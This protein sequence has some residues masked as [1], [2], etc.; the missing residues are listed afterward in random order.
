MF[1]GISCTLWEY[2]RECTL[3]KAEAGLQ[4]TLPMACR[5]HAAF[6]K[7]VQVMPLMVII[8]WFFICINFYPLGLA[9]RENRLKYTMSS[10]ESRL[11]PFSLTLSLFFFLC[12]FLQK[13]SR[14]TIGREN[15]QGTGNMKAT[16]PNHR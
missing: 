1:E 6:G 9:Q 14:Y 13:S 2:Q 16:Y 7:V 12:L 4:K 5:K 3:I 15:M 8:T 11:S 10:T